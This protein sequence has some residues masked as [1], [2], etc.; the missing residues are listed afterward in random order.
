MKISMANSDFRGYVYIVS[1]PLFNGIKVGY[2]LKDPN[3]R[4]HDFDTSAL[5]KKFRLDFFVHISCCANI[6]EQSVHK[7]L[8][9]RKFWITPDTGAG[10][11]WFSCDLLIAHEIIMD[12]IN[13]IECSIIDTYYNQILADIISNN[14]KNI[15]IEDYKKAK[16]ERW[17][18]RVKF[19]K[20]NYIP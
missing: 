12:T 16:Q 8:K 10:V 5:P 13:S 2:S 7:I 18:E 4:L 9:E 15:E 14:K 1:N 19:L 20:N 11:E 17:N 6:I 3:I